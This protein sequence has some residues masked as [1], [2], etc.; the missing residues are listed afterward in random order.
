MLKADNHFRTII[1][2][3]SS[4]QKREKTRGHTHIHKI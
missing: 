2:V 1:E 3:P 4:V